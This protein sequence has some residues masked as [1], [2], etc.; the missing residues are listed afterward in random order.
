MIIAHEFQ[1]TISRLL[2]LSLS[3]VSCVIRT[4]TV[5]FHIHS[6]VC[7]LALSFLFFLI[8]SSLSSLYCVFSP[9]KST[10]QQ[11]QQQLTFAQFYLGF[12]FHFRFK[13]QGA[14]TFVTFE[15]RGATLILELHF[16]LNYTK[17]Q[18]N[19]G[20]GNGNV[21]AHNNGA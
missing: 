6:N 11:Q 20:N 18:N 14:P 21:C 15:S 19:D 9:V 13:F 7:L 1:V 8:L 10:Q 17:K 4:T 5:S 2:A 3:L 12:H 16:F